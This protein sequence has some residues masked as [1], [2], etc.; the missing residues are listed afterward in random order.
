MASR[1]GAAAGVCAFVWGRGGGAGQG[2][3]WLRGRRITL[4]GERVAVPGLQVEGPLHLLQGARPVPPLGCN[5][6]QPQA[7]VDVVRECVQHRLRPGRPV[8]SQDCGPGTRSGRRFL[9][10]VSTVG[11]GALEGGFHHCG[12]QPAVCEAWGGAPA[13]GSAFFSLFFFMPA[14]AAPGTRGRPSEGRWRPPAGAP[15]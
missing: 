7:A 2:P 6:R 3:R 15:C 8:I 4:P 5:R 10:R 11:S 12:L 1:G 13:A 14:A 9:W